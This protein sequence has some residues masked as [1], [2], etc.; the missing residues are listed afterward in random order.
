MQGENVTSG[1]ARGLRREI[2]LTWGLLAATCVSAG[3][4]AADMAG[5]LAGAIA[6]GNWAEAASAA[7]AAAVL[8]CVCYGVF[9][10]HV[11]RIGWLRRTLCVARGTNAKESRVARSSTTVDLP[12]SREPAGEPSMAILVPSYKEEVEVVR[13]TLLSAALQTHANRRIVLLIDDPPVPEDARSRHGLEAARRLPAEIEALFAPMRRHVEAAIAAFENNSST[14]CSALAAL[15]DD[16]ATRLVRATSSFGSGGHE[17][18]FFL[19]G[20]VLSAAR[21]LREDASAWRRRGG[22]DREE[23]ARAYAHLLQRFTPRI[24]AFERKRYANLPHEPNKAMN[25]NGYLA[26]L[27]GSYRELGSG[28]A[29][30]LERCGVAAATIEIPDASLILFLDADTVVLPSYAATMTALLNAPGNERVAVVQ[31]PYSAFPGAPRVLERV[32]GATTDVQYLLHQGMIEAGAGFWVGANAVARVAAL[33]EVAIETSERGWPI[34]KLLH[35][36]TV[37]EDTETTLAL[38]RRGWT[39]LSHLER[40]AFSSTPADFGS[41]LVQRLRWANGG[42]VLVPRLMRA[43]FSAPS[44]AAGAE[45]AMRLHYLVSLGP[46]ALALLALPFCF[47][48]A[49]VR[50]EV[51]PLMAVSYLG[52]YARDLVRCGYAWHDV[53]RVYALNL[54]LIPVNL[55]G[56]LASLGQIVTGAKPRFRRTP[57]IEARTPVPGICI[58]AEV[59]MLCFW[60]AFAIDTALAG[61]VIR[62]GLVLSHIALLAY[63]V[64]RFIG[65]GNAAA[66]FVVDARANV[67]EVA[68]VQPAADAAFGAAEVQG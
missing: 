52:L 18:R 43:L 24:A 62:A 19:D 44:R 23:M 41:L 38:R 34:R 49:D 37:I 58:V 47:Y 16:L 25:L 30:V 4:P 31:T 67:P 8:A 54:L 5:V 15:L 12:V 68:Q 14:K 9:V 33:R 17:A 50:A 46:T 53:L 7:L 21:G 40:L 10:H 45:L 57:K 35:D 36:E 61:G 28:A 32:A 13:R 63:A 64:T 66:D 11:A 56:L 22:A 48:G 51:L 1:D 27:G 3:F 39:V 60:L 2:A 20:C 55:A 42:V 29:T 59:A 6:T 65:W 26:L